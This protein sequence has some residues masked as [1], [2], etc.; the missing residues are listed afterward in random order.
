MPNAIIQWSL[1]H[2]AGAN[3]ANP[4]VTADT[5]AQYAV[6]VTDPQGCS[7]FD[8]VNVEVVFS[9]LTFFSDTSICAGD[10]V[11]I[12]AGFPECRPYLEHGATTQSITV[13]SAGAYPWSCW[14]C[15][16]PA[17]RRSPPT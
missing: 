6:Q 2:P 1:P 7:A 9:S 17:N 13:F 14:T 10:S 15:S 16:P 12:D 4:T 5:T 3:T 11:A 8:T